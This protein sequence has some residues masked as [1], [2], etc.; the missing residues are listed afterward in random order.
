MK[1]EI[2][3]NIMIVGDFNTPI[4][5]M[6]E[7]SRPKIKNKT[8]DL[9]YMLHQKNLIDI[10]ITFDPTTAEYTFFSSTHKIFSRIDNVRPQNRS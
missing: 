5:I 2:N 10:Y 7:Q 4:S 6:V 8:L 3:S 9:N 1:G